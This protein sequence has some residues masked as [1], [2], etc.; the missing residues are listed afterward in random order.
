M[1]N[2]EIQLKN[3]VITAIA[4][5][6]EN[7]DDIVSTL[8]YSG[9]MKE[10][11]QV[12]KGFDNL[13][14]NATEDGKL[15]IRGHLSDKLIKSFS[16][17]ELERINKI[18][19]LNMVQEMAMQKAENKIQNDNNN[20]FETTIRISEEQL[21][22]I[23]QSFGVDVVLKQTKY[24]EPT[25]DDRDKLIAAT[26]SLNNIGIE[27]HFET[28]K[29]LLSVVIEQENIELSEKDVT[30]FCNMANLF[31][32]FVIVPNI[33]DDDKCIGIRILFGIDT[34]VK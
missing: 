22:N 7:V 34:E 3:S 20:T 26:L 21:T 30:I 12:L 27:S 25:D 2:D 16:K 8:V 32:A 14:I 17:E 5:K 13:K 11:A 9:K 19:M 23:L 29:G 33:D 1:F 31:D 18:N 4:N 10:Y 24:R 6:M 15:H 28:K